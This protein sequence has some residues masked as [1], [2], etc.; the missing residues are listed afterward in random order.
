MWE[1]FIRPICLL[2]RRFAIT[3]KAAEQLP[4]IPT[5]T[6]NCFHAR[7][8]NFYKLRKANSISEVLLATENTDINTVLII[9]LNTL[10]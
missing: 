4:Y 10:F 3:S 6:M 1:N 9:L 8:L 7:K 2:L 5:K